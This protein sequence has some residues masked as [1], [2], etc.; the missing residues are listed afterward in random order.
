[1]DTRGPFLQHSGHVLRF[2]GYWDNRCD[3][4]GDLRQFVIHYFLSDGCMEVRELIKANSGYENYPMF[5]R[6]AKIP[7]VIEQF[8]FKSLQC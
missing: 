3:L 8:S 2:W 7:K 5:V 6:K 4:N 1:M